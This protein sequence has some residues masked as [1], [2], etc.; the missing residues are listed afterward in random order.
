MINLHSEI[1]TLVGIVALV[2]LV[3]VIMNWGFVSKN[4]SFWWQSNVTNSWEEEVID[5]PT[6]KL[7]NNSINN[8]SD[9]VPDNSTDDS[10]N[11]GSDNTPGNLID[12]SAGDL[13]EPNRITIAALK[14]EAPLVYI[15]NVGEGYF[16]EALQFGVVHYPGT[17]LLG[18]YGNAFYFGHSSDFNYKA[19]EYKT[20][21]A[22][23]PQ[24]GIG[25]EIKTT[26]AGGRVYVYE[27]F[28]TLVVS[29]AQT[30]VLA[31]GDRSEQILTLQTSY[32]VGT[33]FKR[34][35]VQ[36]KLVN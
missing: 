4:I 18:S 24:I 2:L 19:G 9:N 5:N 22:L 6:N 13:A 17:A 33:A 31:Q 29:P 27:V 25:A 11:N 8:G 32:P 7:P 34:F 10:A 15:D 30:E 20:V 3:F 21:F 36:A 14:I 23:L 16:Q 26:D 12:S 28:N 1:K 35:I